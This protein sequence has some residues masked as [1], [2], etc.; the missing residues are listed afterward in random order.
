[1]VCAVPKAGSSSIKSMG[2]RALTIAQAAAIFAQHDTY[3]VALVRDPFA[4]SISWYNDK[5]LGG[6]PGPGFYNRALHISNDS[7]PRSMHVY[8]AALA[9]EGVHTAEPHLRSQTRHCALHLLHFDIVHPLESIS[10][11]PSR[12]SDALG[13]SNTTRSRPLPTVHAVRSK[14]AA[15]NGTAP[16][17]DASLRHVLRT[18]YA[19]DFEWI[20]RHGVNY[21]HRAGEACADDASLEAAVIH[22][23]VVD[24]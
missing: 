18:A 5:V 14:P 3:R 23:K 11:L 2:A 4:R 7:L 9:R 8:A 24:G 10:S 19:S 20:R 12:V 6:T 13:L 15:I 21:M 22:G 1:M 17:H 16:C